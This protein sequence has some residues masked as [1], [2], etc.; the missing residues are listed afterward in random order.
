MLTKMLDNTSLH[1]T[2]KVHSFQSSA[3]VLEQTMRQKHCIRRV[4]RYLVIIPRSW[5]S[6]F[7]VHFGGH[8]PCVPVFICLIIDSSLVIFVSYD[9]N[10]I[11]VIK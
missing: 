10:T 3:A 9:V 4:T 1:V 2:S 8:V 5:K 11:R 6:Q 7:T